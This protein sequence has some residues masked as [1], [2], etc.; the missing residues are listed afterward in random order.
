MPKRTCTV[1]GCARPHFARGL[2]AMH[3]TRWRR[4]RDLNAGWPEHDPT[5]TIPGCEREYHCRGL[6]EMHYTQ[7]RREGAGMAPRPKAR[8]PNAERKAAPAKPR[9]APA[10]PDYGGAGVP[11]IVWL[12]RQKAQLRR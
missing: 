10:R 2:C 7:Q 8:K 9:R 5:C 4:H 3:H 1:A 12:E 6:C 11:F